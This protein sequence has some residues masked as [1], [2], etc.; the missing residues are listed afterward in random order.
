MTKIE[1]RLEDAAYTLLHGIIPHEQLASESMARTPY[2]MAKALSELCCGY[3]EDTREILSTTFPCDGYRGIVA[4]PRIRFSSLCEHHV[5]PFTGTCSV[6][7]IPGDRIVGLSK[8]PRVVRA[9]SRRLQVQE[10]LTVEIADAMQALNPEAVAVIVRAEHTC[11]CLRG[12]ESQGEMVTS[13]VRG[14]FRH[15]AA[16]RDEVLRLCGEA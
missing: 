11:K 13:E 14:K 1:A 7:Y 10:R 12:I 3:A 6:A 16:A 2:R 8:I 15:E 9:V 4:V 5:L